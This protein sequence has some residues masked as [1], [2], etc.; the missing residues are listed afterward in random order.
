MGISSE[1]ISARVN[2]LPKTVEGIVQLSHVVTD[3]ICASSDGYYEDLLLLLLRGGGGGG[4]LRRCGALIRS[5]RAGFETYIEPCFS[6]SLPS[7]IH[8][9]EH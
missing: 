1:S 2:I 5:L 7:F 6:A 8:R 4:V 9:P 3:P